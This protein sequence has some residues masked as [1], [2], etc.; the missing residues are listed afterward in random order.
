[1]IKAEAHL[2]NLSTDNKLSQDKYTWTRRMKYK[3]ILLKLGIKF[4]RNKK[5][6]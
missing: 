5:K 6:K 2:R 3:K 4:K 1:M